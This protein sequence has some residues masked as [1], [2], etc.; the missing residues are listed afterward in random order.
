VDDGDVRYARSGELHIA[1]KIA[2]TGPPD[3]VLVPGLLDTI[4]GEAVHAPIA[5]FTQ[6][7]SRF[8][9]VIRLDKR[10]TGL[11]DRL[12]PG[13]TPTVEARVDDVLAVMDAAQS[14]RAAVVGTADG[15]AVAIVLAASHPERV[16]ALVLSA[17]AARV[18]PAPDYPWGRSDEEYARLRTLIA[19]RWGTGMVAP[20]FGG[21][22]E[23]RREFARLERLTGTPSAAQ[24]MFDTMRAT[25]VRSV[26]PMIT[27]PTLIVHNVDHQVWPV[28]GARYL[29]EHIAGARLVELPGQ[30]EV[31]GELPRDGP[32]FSELIEEFVTGSR[33]AAPTDRVLKTIVFTDIVGSTERLAAVGDR[34]W[35]E[36]L[37]DY[38]TKVD[39]ALE[40]FRGQRVNWTGDGYFAAFDGAARAIECARTLVLEARRLGVDLRAGVHTGE[41]EVRGDDYAGIAVH[42]GARVGAIA[43]PGEVL[44]TSTVRDLVA[45]SG[46]EF[47]DRGVHALK[48]VPGEWQLLAVV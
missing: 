3:V 31:L 8:A 33:R 17:T 35:S 10:G 11:S 34:R 41:C 32:L 2:G 21:N 48:G 4:E 43:A 19:E 24:R 45:G 13:D 12:P 14:Q 47:A 46:L 36:L 26:L 18:A 42:I 40:R 6:R 15:G 16:S 38:D 9:R 39:A 27:A 37:D 20:F 7:L 28:E 25:D 5:R 30:P 22:D 1:Y 23:T 29:A 44:V